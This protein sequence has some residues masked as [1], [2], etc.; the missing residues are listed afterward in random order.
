MGELPDDF[1]LIAFIEGLLF[2][3]ISLPDSIMANNNLNTKTEFQP[4]YLQSFICRYSPFVQDAVI[5]PNN[6]FSIICRLDAQRSLA[7]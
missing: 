5:V 2:S 3:E 1:I 7:R 6:K 4:I